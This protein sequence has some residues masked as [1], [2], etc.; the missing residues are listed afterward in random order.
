MMIKGM[1]AFR[2]CC[3]SVISGSAFPTSIVLAPAAP[4]GGSSTCPC[5]S[6]CGAALGI[7]G[8]GEN[9][10]KPSWS[11]RPIVGYMLC[12]KPK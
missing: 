12:W 3:L 11:V 8:G 6:S 5:L 1:S 10:E 7:M 9:P 2:F 4:A